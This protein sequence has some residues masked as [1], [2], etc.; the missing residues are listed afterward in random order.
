MFVSVR[1]KFSL[2]FVLQLGA[3]LAGSQ[4]RLQVSSAMLEAFDVVRS[5]M[6][7]V[8]RESGGSVPCGQLEDRR[9]ASLLETYS[10]RLLQMVEEKMKRV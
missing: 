5:D 8:L 4:R 2:L 6:Q 9:T 3:T 7:E 1:L 10:E